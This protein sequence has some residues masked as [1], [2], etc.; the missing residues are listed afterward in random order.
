MDHCTAGRRNR[1][2]RA[3]LARDLATDS[4]TAL[5]HKRAGIVMK[6]HV[7]CDGTKTQFSAVADEPRDPLRYVHRVVNKGG[8]A[9]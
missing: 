4:V 1:V 2:L 8:R 6:V 5:R 7:D 3:G 9:V